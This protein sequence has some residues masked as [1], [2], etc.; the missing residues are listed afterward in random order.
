MYRRDFL[1]AAALT[2][3][4]LLLPDKDALPKPQ[5]STDNNLTLHN[6]FLEVNFDKQGLLSITDKLNSH[7]LLFHNDSA[8]ITVNDYTL[9]TVNA[10]PV[11]IEKEGN[12]LSYTSTFNGHSLKVIYELKPGWSFVS[13]Q[14]IFDPQKQSE[15]YHVNQVTVMKTTLGNTVSQ[16][17]RIY[18]GSRGAF[19]R[20]GDASSSSSFGMLLTLQNPM[21]IW[22]LQNNEAIV[23]YTPD[24][25]WKT[26]YGSFETDRAIIAPYALSGT[27]Y[28]MGDIPEWQHT[29]DPDAVG[30]K[31]E[32]VDMAEV[33]S[34][35]AA[36]RAFM[37]VHP[38]KTTS[39]HV[40]WTE[41]DY[42]IDCGTEAGRTE[43]KRI[44]DRVSQLGIKNI[45]YAPADSQVSSLDQNTD[46]WGWENSLWFGLGQKI[47]KGEWIPGKDPI[48]SSIKEMLNYAKSRN[49]KLV[50]YAYPSLGFMQNPEWTRWCNNKP[51]GYLGADTGI[52]SF[53]DWFVDQLVAFHEQTGSGG[54]SF[55]HWWIAYDK[56]ATSK[57]AQWYGCR[58]ILEMLRR[59]APDIVID[60]RQQYQWFG[61]WTWVGGSYPHPFGNDEQPAS[62][63]AHPDLHTDRVSAFH[64]R[65]I[66]WNYRMVNFTPVELTPGY[67]THQT[68]RSDANGVMHRDTW[69]TRDWDILGWRYSVLSSIATGPMN[70]VV[71]MLPARDIDEFRDF[72]TKDIAWFR[73]WLE[74]T[75]TNY[76]Y[77]LRIRP[78]LGQPLLGRVDGASAIIED[79]GY[80]FLF[81][82]NYRKMNAE[83][84]LDNS[85]GLQKG[86]SFIL[87]EIEPLE[88]K[89]IGK[90]DA[91]LWEFGDTVSIPMEGVSAVVLRVEPA[92]KSSRPMLFNLPGNAALKDGT[93]NITN[94]KGE[95]GQSVDLIASMPDNTKVKLVIVNGKRIDFTQNEN[96]VNARVQF[97]GA[98]FQQ[99][100]QVGDYDPKFNETA[101][102][103]EFTIPKR[104]FDQLAARKKAWPV[105][106]TEDDLLATWLGP[107]R[108]FLFVNIAE[109][110]PEMKVQMKINGQTIDVKKAWNGIYPNSGNQTFMG[111]YAE[112][113]AL[114]PDTR[115]QVDVTLPDN[116][117][118]GQ[119]QGLYFDNVEPEYTNR[120][121]GE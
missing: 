85:I 43:Y 25:D 24:M 1:K 92:K 51:G 93:L 101:F 70:N 5:N 14:L 6:K 62:F 27:E 52:R 18:G 58:R 53:Q 74:W 67:M 66:S 35:A 80:L 28:P 45:L 78:I 50:A 21:V 88:G 12:S 94:A 4:A 41:N 72:H 33:D 104:V 90:P 95:C 36:V 100:Q 86:Q 32:K 29:P 26:E 15:V 103:G 37:V 3:A 106:Y 71:D 63:T 82:P 113:T 102:T 107:N 108:L 31:G 40:G 61:P 23:S 111:F 97:D 96:I 121:S 84:K 89:R 38:S 57:Y 68:Q 49:V 44:I 13:K 87:R 117:K 47:R 8:S 119:F 46:A 81:N 99:C 16:E 118:P 48:P 30:M 76:R 91:G 20:I 65:A 114:T 69:R 110:K 120:I 9:D 79:N 7:T 22:S 105:P 60:G 112:V 73:K 17:H 64:Q 54:F 56:P 83:F 11:K 39:I 55:D 42:Q 77:I 2:G 98:A 19:L 34:F 109:P 75:E 10:D 59:R 115:Y 116:L